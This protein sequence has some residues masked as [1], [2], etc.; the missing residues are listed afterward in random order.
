MKRTLASIATA[1]L[2]VG[3]VPAGAW[4]GDGATPPDPSC[5][6][7]PD[8]CQPADP[9]TTDDCQGLRDTVVSLLAVIDE[10]RRSAAATSDFLWGQIFAIRAQLAAAQAQHATDAARLA[11]K[12]ATIDRLRALV[13]QK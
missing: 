13:R 3:L 9:G 4:A 11:H 7:A 5:V 12:Q 1:V 6:A 10:D 8:K 2:L